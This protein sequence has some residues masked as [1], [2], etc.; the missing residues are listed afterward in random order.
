MRSARWSNYVGALLPAVY[1]I[2][3]I[4]AASADSEC[5]QTPI[6]SSVNLLFHST[7]SSI[8]LCPKSTRFTS[9]RKPSLAHILRTHRIG[10]QQVSTDKCIC[11][12]VLRVG[13]GKT[14]S[15]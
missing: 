8:I 11:T 1:S 9:G 10:P 4:S 3:T 12:F 7:H 15:G 14:D 5:S 13:E 6:W 2:Y